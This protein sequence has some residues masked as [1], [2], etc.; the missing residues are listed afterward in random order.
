MGE[1]ALVSFRGVE[2]QRHQ[3]HIGPLDLDIPAGC[4]TAIV[5]MNG[6]GKSTMMG[7][8]LGIVQPDAG[9][10][11][12]EGQTHDDNRDPDWKAR[13]G[14]QAELPNFEDDDRTPDQLAKQLAYWYPTWDGL[15]YQKLIARY[16]IDPWVKLNKMSKGM[17]RKAELVLAL[18]H[19]PEV[20][21]LDEP[22]SGL[23]PISWRMMIEDLQ[24]LLRDGKH[25]IIIATHVIEE[26]K[27][28]ADYI[29]FMHRGKLLTLVEKD[30]LFDAWKEYWL[31]GISAQDMAGAPGLAEAI[32]EHQVVRAIAYDA[33]Q[34]EEY[35]CKQQWTP[36]RRQA[37]PLDEVMYYRI[38]MEDE[39]RGTVR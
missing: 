38:R 33:R 2:K 37:M 12:I 22:T 8:L 32:Q 21:L 25:T 26:V 28:L 35:F 3:L 16:E 39:R 1:H 18:A 31:E 36:I 27:R 9:H 20:L 30:E 14:Y 19:R 11:L 7:I 24:D 34:L 10:M 13:I 5:G 4:V 29:C 15:W 17:R 6:S 23:D